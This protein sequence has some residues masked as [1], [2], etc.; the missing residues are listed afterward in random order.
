MSK[1][2]RLLP[3]PSSAADSAVIGLSLTDE[4]NTSQFQATGE[5]EAN[6]SAY[7]ANA[8]EYPKIIDTV[9]SEYNHQSG[10]STGQSQC[11]SYTAGDTPTAALSYP[12]AAQDRICYKNE[13]DVEFQLS[14][15]ENRTASFT[16]KRAYEHLLLNP[17]ERL[18]P[19][20][21]TQRL[22]FDA[23]G[24]SEGIRSCQLAQGA[25]N[26]TGHNVDSR[27]PTHSTIPDFQLLDYY[28]NLVDTNPYQLSAPDDL[29]GEYINPRTAFRQVLPY[30]QLD[31]SS[32]D[33]YDALPLIPGS[34]D[35]NGT[36]ARPLESQRTTT[37][38]IGNDLCVDFGNYL[39][40]TNSNDRYLISSPQNR[41]GDESIPSPELT[42]VGPP[43]IH[44]NS[45]T[46]RT[47]LDRHGDP[48]HR[49]VHPL[50]GHQTIALGWMQ[51]QEADE[52]KKGGILADAM[53][54]GKTIT[55]LA[56]IMTRPPVA[57]CNSFPAPT[58]VVAPTALLDQWE[59]EAADKVMIQYRLKI[60]NAHRHKCTYDELRSCDLVL[61]SYGK[62]RN[63]MY[64][65]DQHLKVRSVECGEQ[66]SD[67]LGDRFPFMA[68]QSLFYR[69]ILD[70]AQVVKNAKTDVARA[71]RKI[72]AEYRWCLTATPMMNSVNELAALLQFLRIEPYGNPQGVDE[73]FGT[74][75]GRQ[76]RVRTSDAPIPQLGALLQTIMLRRTQHSTI[77]GQPILNLP[78]KFE[79]VDSVVLSGRERDCYQH[80]ETQMRLQVSGL[81][82]QG[83][84]RRRYAASLGMLM[85]LSQACC[86]PNTD[87]FEQ[88]GGADKHLP[89]LET[90][91]K[92]AAHNTDAR[93]QYMKHLRTISSD[94]AKIAK[95]IEIL[96]STTG[97]VL[98]FSQWTFLLDLLEAE[99]SRE[100]I[101][102]CR[103]DGAMKPHQRSNT[104]ASF[105][106]GNGIKVMLIS[107]HAGNCGLNLSAASHV[108]LMDPCWNPFVEDQA[109]GR[110]HRI[111]QTQEVH[112]HRILAEGTV[113]DRIIEFQRRKRA[114]VNV[115]LGDSA[116]QSTGELSTDDLAFLCGLVGEKGVHEF[117]DGA[118]AD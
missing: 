69:I 91:R 39:V 14:E 59:S 109:I 70:E 85:R 118:I 24:S 32:S 20:P 63:E 3:A 56:L 72:R 60:L 73:L 8:L 106:N 84:T 111:G 110:A 41:V 58:L 64:A 65:L 11:K 26:Y 21:K 112:V 6:V 52:T 38:P 78:R 116:A 54:L 90:L 9:I 87:T 48:A 80:A 74:L 61:T 75:H 42:L 25:L 34:V 36:C 17:A 12:L 2:R 115:V 22:F 81:I 102:F 76:Q 35:V 44:E 62:L 86:Y 100:R 5:T 82:A 31:T 97:K 28:S 105:T 40:P 53:G 66:L 57:L 92:H 49:M 18:V 103:Y 67:D 94:S 95:C 1:L 117:E 23:E 114:Q 83:L 10:P 79:W 71:V 13:P 19:Q 104:V 68:P 108:I 46:D 45:P 98:V 113:E 15:T 7:H 50:Y 47:M 99:I 30:M 33:M 37:L 107:L 51:Q 88:H 93:Q 55:T 96:R 77:R 89:N 16:R 27:R 101:D 29:N 4:L 43:E